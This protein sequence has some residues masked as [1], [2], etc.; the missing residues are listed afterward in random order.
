MTSYNSKEIL[1]DYWYI[2]A[3]S[4]WRKGKLT[5]GSS[6]RNGS[7]ENAL[8]CGQID[9]NRWISTR[10][11][12]LTSK[13]LLDRHDVFEKFTDFDKNKWLNNKTDETPG[14]LESEK[15][16]TGARTKFDLQ[17]ILNVWSGGGDLFIVKDHIFK[18]I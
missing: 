9:L 10:I 12:N 8:F 15:S 1:K 6:R 13:N 2:D 7:S 3:T 18:S 16:Q 5:S 14:K 17:M 11:V 4:K